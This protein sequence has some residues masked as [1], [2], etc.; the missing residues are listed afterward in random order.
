MMQMKKRMYQ[1]SINIKHITQ[2]HMFDDIETD[3]VQMDK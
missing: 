2:L 1:Q 3:E